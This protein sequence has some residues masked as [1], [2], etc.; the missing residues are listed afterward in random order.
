M[1]VPFLEGLL[2]FSNACQQLAQLCKLLQLAQ[3]CKLEL[4]GLLGLRVRAR[5]YPDM[6]CVL[7]M[8]LMRAI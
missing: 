7:G 8:L 5:V 2:R 3:L 6:H 4:A 1:L